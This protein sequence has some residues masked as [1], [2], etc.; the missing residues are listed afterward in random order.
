MSQHPQ[1]TNLR[2]A[3]IWERLKKAALLRPFYQSE[4]HIWIDR[5][6]NRFFEAAKTTAS[7]RKTGN[8]PVKQDRKAKDKDADPRK[9]KDSTTKKEEIILNILPA[10]TL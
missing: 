3:D 1:K 5:S 9:L 4:F 8:K 2:L 6:L 7:V 10:K